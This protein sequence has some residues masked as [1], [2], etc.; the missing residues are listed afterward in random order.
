MSLT[1]YCFGIAL[2]V[3]CST[4]HATTFTFNT[5]PFAGTNVL[6]TPGRQIVAGENFISFSTAT[7]VFSLDPTV[8]GTGGTVNF[9]NALASAIPTSGVNVVVLE[10]FDDDNNPATPFGAGQAANLIA[11]RITTPGAGFFIYFNQALDLPRLVYSTDLSDPNA[12]LKILAR[13]LNLNGAN[14]RNELSTFSAS[15]FSMTSGVPEP[16]S[17]TMMAFGLVGIGSYFLRRN[18]SRK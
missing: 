15:N 4:A 10:S 9:V 8:F 17:L 14:G 3:M 18:Q 7:D 5:D 1:K 16:S 11:D 13:M 2:A 12:D 6:N